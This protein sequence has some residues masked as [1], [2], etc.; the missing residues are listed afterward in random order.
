MDNLPL[1]VLHLAPMLKDSIIGIPPND[2]SPII[3]LHI[4]T[5]TAFLF[6][7][8][9]CHNNQKG[10]TVCWSLMSSGKESIRL[11]IFVKGKIMMLKEILVKSSLS[12]E[13]S[14]ICSI[15]INLFSEEQ[16]H[17]K[18]SLQFLNIRSNKVISMVNRLIINHNAVNN[19][20]LPSDHW[21]IPLFP[22]HNT[23][24]LE[25]LKLEQDKMLSSQIFLSPTSSDLSRDTFP[26][27]IS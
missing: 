4:P 10:E 9:E 6:K 19:W 25:C 26:N 24:F 21:K 5:V 1:F 27:Q 2:H 18:V 22:N 16:Y 13:K 23:S 11:L 20:Q 7:V 12:K 15:K 8:I 17:S 14:T 3:N